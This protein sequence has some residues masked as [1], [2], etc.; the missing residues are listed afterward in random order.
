MVFALTLMCQKIYNI[1]NCKIHDV[2]GRDVK[3]SEHQPYQYLLLIVSWS[4]HY[5]DRLDIDLVMKVN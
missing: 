1:Y 5:P 4:V 3:G 2:N